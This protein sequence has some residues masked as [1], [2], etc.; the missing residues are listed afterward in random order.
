MVSQK[1]GMIDKK[2]HQERRRI[3][4]K[5]FFDSALKP[6]ETAMLEHI[7]VFLRAVTGPLDANGWS[8]GKDMSVLCK[9]SPYREQRE[10][11]G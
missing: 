3:I 6:F 8:E 11:V 1:G 9:S 5:E 2:T 7:R 10:P 4:S